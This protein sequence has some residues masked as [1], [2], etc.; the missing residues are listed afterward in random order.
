MAFLSGSRTDDSNGTQLP[1]LPQ[2]GTVVEK[3]NIRQERL[4][5]QIIIK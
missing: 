2:N 1:S 4:G 5:D 3:E